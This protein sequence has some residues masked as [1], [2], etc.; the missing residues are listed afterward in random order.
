MVLSLYHPLSYF[1]SEDN[2]MNQILESLGW[3]LRKA[4]LCRAL[5]LL[6]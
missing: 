3:G 6:T 4:P 5:I 2:V 1:L